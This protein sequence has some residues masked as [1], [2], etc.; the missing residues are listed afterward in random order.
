MMTCGKCLTDLQV[1]FIGKPVLSENGGKPYRIKYGDQ[2]RCV[3]C[4][5]TVIGE[6]GQS[7]EV[8][9]DR[10]DN[11]I[12]ELKIKKSNGEKNGRKENTK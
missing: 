8:N 7:I 6:F 1:M 11:L 4:G 2:Y 10:F 12:T 9:D 3:K 5:Y